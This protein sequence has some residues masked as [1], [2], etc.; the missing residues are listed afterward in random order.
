MRVMST[1]L[2]CSVSGVGASH[3]TRT[4]WRLSVDGRPDLVVGDTR[5]NSGER[6]VALIRPEQVPPLPRPVSALLG[7]R[8]CKVD[9]H[10]DRLR[11][12]VG[13]VKPDGVGWPRT[14][15]P[16]MDTLLDICG[17]DYYEAVF[18]HGVT[19]IDTREVILGDDSNHRS[20]LCALLDPSDE[21]APTALYVVTHVVPT[22]KDDSVG[23]L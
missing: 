1:A 15:W 7:K 10:G 13:V 16:A 2:L 4:D 12:A 21:V 14:T 17:R 18:D 20:R 9:A 5:W 11:M 19:Q 3:G 8:R 22:L 6:E 23:W